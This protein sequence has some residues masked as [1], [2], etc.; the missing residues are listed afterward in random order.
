MD[1]KRTVLALYARIAFVASTMSLVACCA[2]AQAP[3]SADTFVSSATPSINYGPAIGLA[4]GPGTTAYIQINLAGIP[5][6]AAVSK[7]TLRLFVDAV[8]KPGSFDV[9]EVDNAWTENKLTYNTPA[10]VPGISATAGNP[11]AVTTASTNQFVLV[12]ITSLVQRWLD[13]NHGD[14]TLLKLRASVGV[15]L[16]RYATGIG[17]FSVVF[18]GANI[19]VADD[20]DTIL[21]RF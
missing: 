6:N 21:S 3:P 11:M 14:N 18:D 13:A 8:G 2:L 16:A 4:V 12:D 7:A 10:P 9:Y 20:G 19:W 15:E 17:P 1:T 5:A